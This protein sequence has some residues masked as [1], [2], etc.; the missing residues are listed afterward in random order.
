MGL[1]LGAIALSGCIRI[2][3]TLPASSLPAPTQAAAAAEAKPVT[4]AVVGEELTHGAWTVTVE[5]A[6]RTADKLGGVKPP[7]GRDFLTVD[8]GFE[9]KG[10][11]SLEVRPEDFQ[12]LDAAGAPMPM[13][14][15]KK[16]AFNANSMRPLM[17]RFGTSTV[18]V[19]TVPRGSSRYALVFTPGGARGKA[20]LEWQVP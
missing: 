14:P 19:Y 9:N 8:V 1:L 15:M 10:T 7:D 4:H 16:P 12:L 13:A 20:R 11:D 6:Q 2:S 5:A 17:P 18:F 3:G